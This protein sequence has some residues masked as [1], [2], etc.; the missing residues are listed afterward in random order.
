MLKM[1]TRI[2]KFRKWFQILLG[3]KRRL[4]QRKW[5][6]EDGESVCIDDPNRTVT[7]LMDGLKQKAEIKLQT[8]AIQSEHEVDI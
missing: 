2:T 4:G 8:A 7:T 3:L 6:A 5:T 1:T